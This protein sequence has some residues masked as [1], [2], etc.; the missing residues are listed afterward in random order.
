VAANYKLL[1]YEGEKMSLAEAGQYSHTK[2]TV[3]YVND[4]DALVPVIPTIKCREFFNEMVQTM[5]TEELNA[6]YGFR[7]SFA[8]LLPLRSKRA[9]LVCILHKDEVDTTINHMHSHG[10]KTVT[11]EGDDGV[12]GVGVRLTDVTNPL[13]YG[14]LS[15]LLRW[16]GSLQQFT[17][18]LDVNLAYNNHPIAL[19]QHMNSFNGDVPRIQKFIS[20]ALGSTEGLFMQALV[21]AGLGRGSLQ[22]FINYCADLYP[23]GS[24]AYL[25][26]LKKGEGVHCAHG[27]GVLS[28]MNDMTTHLATTGEWYNRQR[29]YFGG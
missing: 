16:Y 7:P 15:G 23:N 26:A 14:F 24:L 5:A 25:L 20:W 9:Y 1:P 3:A 8:Q 22:S 29:K 11:V 27:Y 2:F 19:V 4:D 21:K 13:E 6:V 28:A 18:G 12:F 17:K 10:I